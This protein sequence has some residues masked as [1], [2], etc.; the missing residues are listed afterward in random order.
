MGRKPT[1]TDALERARSVIKSAK[2]IEDLQ[3]AQSVLLPLE[4]GLTIDQTAAAI[5]KHPS[6]V[7]RTRRRFISAEDKTPPATR[8]GR[9]HGT[10]SEEDEVQL[11]KRALV[12]SNRIG[13]PGIHG[14]LREL[15]EERGLNPHPSTVTAIMQRV[16]SKLFSG[17]KASFLSENRG[18][19]SQLWSKEV[20]LKMRGK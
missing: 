6:W 1:G 11:V 20:R 17:Q 10:V 14:Q 13:G 4:F 8:G 3:A 15:L 9:R 7:S 12:L 16:T 19:L 18:P 2:T 5:G